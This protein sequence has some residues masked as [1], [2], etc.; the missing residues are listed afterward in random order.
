MPGKDSC[1]GNGGDS[2][3]FSLMRIFRMSVRF[4]TCEFQGKRVVIEV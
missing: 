1:M 2:E 4:V 3:A